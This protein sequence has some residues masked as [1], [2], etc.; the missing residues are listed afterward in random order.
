MGS[1]GLPVRKEAPEVGW[2][3]ERHKRFFGDDLDVDVLAEFPHHRLDRWV[4]GVGDANDVGTD[5]VRMRDERLDGSSTEDGDVHLYQ[6]LVDEDQT[7]KAV[8]HGL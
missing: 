5:T 6:G 1:R 3:L 2:S 8:V 4:G 7:L